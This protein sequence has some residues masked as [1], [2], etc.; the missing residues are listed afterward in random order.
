MAAETIKR[1]HVPEK[2]DDNLKQL[3]KVSQE[4]V[5]MV[6]K[7]KVAQDGGGVSLAMLAQMSAQQIQAMDKMPKGIKQAS[8]VK[9]MDQL[10]AMAINNQKE[11]ILQLADSG[12]APLGPTSFAELQVMAK[13]NPEAMVKAFQGNVDSIQ[14]EK[15]SDN[16]NKKT[17]AD[18]EVPQKKP[19]LSIAVAA[20]SATYDRY[21]EQIAGLIF[22]CKMSYYILTLDWPD[23]EGMEKLLKSNLDS[24]SKHPVTEILPYIQIKLEEAESEKEQLAAAFILASVEEKEHTLLDALI[25]IWKEKEELSPIIIKAFNYS[26]NSYV[27]PL[28]IETFEKEPVEVG[29]SMISILGYHQNE[30]DLQSLFEKSEPPVQAQILKN[31]AINGIKFE[32]SSYSHL[33]EEDEINTMETALLAALIN[34]EKEALELCRALCSEKYEDLIS[35]PLYLVCSGD[36][37]DLKS[38]KQCLSEEKPQTAHI[39]ALGIFG[40]ASLVPDLISLLKKEKISVENYGMHRATHESLE[41]ITGADLEIPMPDI[42]EGPEDAREKITFKDHYYS[43]WSKWW[44]LNGQSFEQD[45]RYRRGNPL[46]DLSGLIN[47][48]EN[49]RGDYWSR[50]NSYYELMIRSGYR[51]HFEADWYVP[52]QMESI[53]NLW[54][55]WRENKSKLIT[56]VGL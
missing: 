18:E 22:I 21:F 3:L 50:Q 47:E 54:L 16:A 9:S 5:D 31:S 11:A 51:F 43:V 34:G 17:E 20:K 6:Q 15:K 12:K 1:L 41:L 37:G 8:G 10:E 56:L 55:W 44:D 2:A 26:R 24:L 33:L 53:E 32:Y 30:L 45:C 7:G 27:D 4:M 49:T 29:A 25:G 38:L 40:V 28:F 13:M 19:E 23:I 46:T 35:A 52:Q 39:Q 42:E 36:L 14:S 48:I